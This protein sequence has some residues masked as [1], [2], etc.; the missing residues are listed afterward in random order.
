MSIGVRAAALFV[1]ILAASGI[2]RSQNEQAPI[3]QK[4][5]TYK[6]WT[7][8]SIRT[9]ENVNLRSYTQGKKLT[10]VVYFAPWC[11]N[12]AYDAPR[13]QKF[14]DNYK[15]KGLGI[16]AVGLYDPLDSMKANL[17][18]LKI[19]FP[20][21]YESAE[22]NA[23]ESSLHF[24]YRRS[25]GDLRKWGSP[26]YVFLLPQMMEKSRDVL[27]R[28]T[29]IVNGEVVETEADAFI[30][31]TLGLAGDTK[32]S[33]AAREKIE[34]CEPDALPTFKKPLN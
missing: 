25:T 14:Y 32:G 30:R 19:T 17:D 29:F 22:R 13:L 20:A 34:A 1:L 15:D 21:V 9:G 27:T 16:I 28:N 23:R 26:W 12:W 7:Y 3:Q 5:I 10:M 11:G 18:R 33:V 8:K 24:Q 6:D 2:V 4:D 31:K